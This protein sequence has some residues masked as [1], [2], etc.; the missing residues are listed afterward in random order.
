M[1]RSSR[2]ICD[3]AFGMMS[4]LEF[5]PNSPPL[6]NAGTPLGQLSACVVLPVEDSIESI[7]ASLRSM[8]VIH[9]SGGGEGITVYRYGSKA[10]QVPAFAVQDKEG[11]RV[12]PYEYTRGCE[13]EV[14]E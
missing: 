13:G 2:D 4:R 3:S 7:F 9:Q 1:V 10:Q 8:A 6:M 12:L 5:L 14:C 11:R